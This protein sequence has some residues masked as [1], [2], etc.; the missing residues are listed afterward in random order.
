MR[1]V[2]YMILKTETQSKINI[3]SGLK[4]D[5][6]KWLESNDAKKLGYHSQAQ[7]A[8]EAIRSLL[9]KVTTSKNKGIHFILPN[10]K[11]SKLSLDLN[12]NEEKV[13]CNICDAENCIHVKILYQDKEVKKQIKNHNI[14]LPAKTK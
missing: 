4:D 3:D 10:I 9:Q 13:I 11:E 14:K 7:F 8:T 6:V 5:L 1:I 12:I 2:P